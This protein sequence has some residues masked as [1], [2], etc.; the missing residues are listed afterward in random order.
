MITKRK[1]APAVLCALTIALAACSGETQEP[2][3]ATVNVSAPAT[4]PFAGPITGGEGQLRILAWPGYAENGM[5]DPEA[6]WVTPFTEATGCDVTVRV[7]DSS[8]EAADLMA[9]GAWDVVSASGDITGTLITQQDVQPINTELLT[10]YEDLIPELRGQLWNSQE[11]TVYG[12]PHGRAANILAFNPREI[13]PAP[14]S[15]GITWNSDSAAAGKVTASTST[16]W[17]DGKLLQR[18]A[19]SPVRQPFAHLVSPEHFVE[20]S[21]VYVPVEHPPLQAPVAIGNAF[22]GQMGE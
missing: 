17:S 5:V 10:N 20:G 16:R 13:S 18:S 15:W 22:P 8:D 21:G 19:F 1:P 4:V 6:D 3:S 2:S 7:I 12:V 14:T 11:G 9:T